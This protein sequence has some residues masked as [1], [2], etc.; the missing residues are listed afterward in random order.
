MQGVGAGR[1]PRSA[2]S[3]PALAYVA[4]VVD[5]P[6]RVA[7]V[8]ERDL[9]LPRTEVPA[10]GGVVPWVAVGESAV[11]VFGHGHDFLGGTARSGV[12]HLAI[13][14]PNPAARAAECGFAD[15]DASPGIGGGSQ[16]E[17]ST[18]DT[19][20]IATRLCVPIGA[21]PTAGASDHV[22]R[23]DHLGVASEDNRAAGAVFT[24]RLGCPVESTQTDFEVSQPIES[25]TSDKYGVVYHSR[26]PEPIGGLR[27]SFLS[28]GDCEL[29]LLQPFDPH[30][31]GQ[32]A[33][34][35]ERGAPGNTRGDKGAIARYI[36]RRGPG[37]HHLALK[38]PDIDAALDRLAAA[39]H[40]V[41]DRV[42]RPGSRRARIGFV[43]PASLG[44]LLLHFVERDEL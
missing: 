6:E 15:S 42:G 38:T 43:H 34:G 8:F 33:E 39:G 5:D 14:T 26:P 35:P 32:R 23:I 16:V 18:R 10:P 44:G 17:L 9:G 4:V 19:C 20:G 36:E 2:A 24:D 27:V 13:A 7:A 11:A 30:H 28:V 37:L 3:V 12:H 31:A 40:R 21:G 29:E 22:E 41:I 1:M 25:F